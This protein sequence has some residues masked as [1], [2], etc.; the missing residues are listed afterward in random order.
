VYILRIEQLQE[1]Q[2]QK[3]ITKYLLYL[4][5]DDTPFMVKDWVLSQLPVDKNLFE[6]FK[7]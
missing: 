7:A 6:L 1:S 3:I 5:A 2:Q 4:F